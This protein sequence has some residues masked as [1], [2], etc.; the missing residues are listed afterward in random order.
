MLHDFDIEVAADGYG[1][2][3]VD[4]EDLSKDVAGFDL[5]VRPSQVPKLVLFE[6]A[7]GVLTGKADLVVATGGFGALLEA[8]DSVDPVALDAAVLADETVDQEGDDE[9]RMGRAF[10]RHIRADI[11]SREQP[12]G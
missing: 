11:V 5:V 9:G 7:T 10:L 4:G 6:N 1:R 12:P 8:L 3:T 2:L